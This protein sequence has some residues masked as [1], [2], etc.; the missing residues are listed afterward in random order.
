M[1][2]RLSVRRL[3]SRLFSSDRIISSVGWAARKGAEMPLPS[4]PWEEIQ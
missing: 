4:S 3:K 1:L 2:N